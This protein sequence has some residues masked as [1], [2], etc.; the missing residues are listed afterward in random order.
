[1][2]RGRKKQAQQFIDEES[3]EVSRGRGASIV[4]RIKEKRTVWQADN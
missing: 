2:L 3:V 4:R 1:M